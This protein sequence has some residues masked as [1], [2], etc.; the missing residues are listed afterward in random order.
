MENAGR[1][2][3][4]EIAKRWSPLQ[5]DGALRTRQ[6]RR[7]RLRRRAS[8]ASARLCGRGR[9]LRRSQRAETRRR[10]DGE[11]MDRPDT[12]FD[13]KHAVH[14]ELYRR[15]DLRRGAQRAACRPN[16]ASCSKTSQSPTSPSSPSTCRAA[17]AAIERD[18]STTA[19]RGRRRSPSHSSARS[20]RTFSTRREDIA[21]RSS[22]STSASRSACC[23][24]SSR[25][26]RRAR[27]P[28]PNCVENIEPP[29]P[30]P[31]ERGQRTNTIA[32]TASSSAARRPRQA[33]PAS[34]RAPRCA[35]AQ[36]SSPSPATHGAAA[37]SSA[38]LT[39]IMVR[40][41]DDGAALAHIAAGQAAQRRRRRPR[42][43]HRP[44]DAGARRWPRFARAPS[45]VLDADAL[46][47]FEGDAPTNS[48]S[49]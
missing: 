34:P 31:L 45:V 6:Q 13:P 32:A 42:Q 15:R 28:R 12:P 29:L 3:A 2:V 11:A 43:R 37:Y 25:I 14:G 18:S 23:S 20:P 21:A 8:S 39:A 41:V 36:A 33:R 48:S 10:S 17:S 46:T 7:R 49:Y 16:S 5:D 9:H 40:E 27:R 26:A 44:T 24:R 19:S 22:A 4:N 30:P 38:S 47:R 1:Q 35:R